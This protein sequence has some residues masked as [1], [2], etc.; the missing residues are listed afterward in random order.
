LL[1]EE[2][3]QLGEKIDQFLVDSAKGRPL[4]RLGEPADI[5]KV[6]LFLCSDLAGWVTGAAI[7][8]DGG[9]IA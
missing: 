7:V 8:V 6:V 4:E 5:A 3:R 9:G 1:R 2:G